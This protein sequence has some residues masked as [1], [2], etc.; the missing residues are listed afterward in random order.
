MSGRNR[1][2]LNTS[3]SKFGKRKITTIT[4]SSVVKL[5]S[6]EVSSINGVSVKDTEQQNIQQTLDI[7]TSKEDIIQLQSKVSILENYVN[8]LRQIISSL[9][10]KTLNNV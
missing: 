8:E 5:Q 9:T 7:D 2:G 6:I 3:A 4:A 1:N 10:N